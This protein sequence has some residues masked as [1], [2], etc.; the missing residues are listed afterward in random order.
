MLWY[1]GIP[2]DFCKLRLGLLI[3]S[4]F[5]SSSPPTAFLKT[6]SASSDAPTVLTPPGREEERRVRIHIQLSEERR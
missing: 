5:L 6:Y 4:Q 3:S 2:Q 1:I